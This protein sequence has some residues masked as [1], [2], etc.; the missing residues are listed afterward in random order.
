MLAEEEEEG[1]KGEL[2]NEEEGR[3]EERDV[4]AVDGVAINVVEEVVQSGS[5]SVI[6]VAGQQVA[7]TTIRRKTNP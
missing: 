1:E 5:S 4:G 6:V 2:E 7:Y 3:E